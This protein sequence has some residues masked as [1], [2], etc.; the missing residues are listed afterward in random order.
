MNSLLALIQDLGPQNF[1]VSIIESGSQ[2]N[3]KGALLEL[4]SFLETLGVEHKILTGINHD[5]QQDM[6]RDLP[7]EGKR[8]GWVYTGRP[9][10]KAGKA[11]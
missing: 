11:G 1:Y 6:L 7:E 10:E 4:K 8:K 3:T 2:D 5:E 9:E